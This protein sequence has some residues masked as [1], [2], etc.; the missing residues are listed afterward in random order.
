M[1]TSVVAYLCLIGLVCLERIYELWLSTRNARSALQAGGIE[2]GRDH[3]PVMV[4]LHSTFL[5]AA[6]LEVVLANRPFLFWPGVVAI[7][8]V[9]AS[10]SLRHWAVNTLGPRW[11]TRV[12]VVPGAPA[13]VS[14]PYRWVRHPNYLAVVVELAALPLVHSAWVTAIAFSLLNAWLLSVRIRVEEDALRRH[15]AYDERMGHRPRLLPG[16]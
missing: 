7:V 4:V 11:N 10:M 14:G 8:A 16:R 13:E 5:V 2:V 6:P 9:C 12:I 3:Y 15:C 1:Q